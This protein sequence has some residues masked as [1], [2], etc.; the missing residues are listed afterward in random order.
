[1]AAVRRLPGVAELRRANGSRYRV[2]S[3]SGRRGRRRRGVP[4]Q[5]QQRSAYGCLPHP[6]TSDRETSDQPGCLI[7]RRLRNATPPV[8]A[9]ARSAINRACRSVSDLRRRNVRD[10]ILM[11]AAHVTRIEGP[12]DPQDALAR[13]APIEQAKG[14]LMAVHRITA[15]EAFALLVARSQRD[16]R[17][18]HDIAREFVHEMSH[19]P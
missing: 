19:L 12:L 3:N 16:N 18:V 14:I 6:R 15:D 17:K 11:S 2:G 10:N 5:C 8:T 1:M 13:R 4:R 9:A 7:T